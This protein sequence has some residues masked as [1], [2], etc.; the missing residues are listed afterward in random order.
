MRLGCDRSPAG[1]VKQRV[2]GAEAEK[3][4]FARP[5][6]DAVVVGDDV[7]VA[8]CG[9]GEPFGLVRD[10]AVS[11]T[12]R[13]DEVDALLLVA[14]HAVVVEDIV[15]GDSDEVLGLGERSGAVVA[16]D[17]DE[18]VAD[19]CHLGEPD[20]GGIGRL[21]VELVRDRAPLPGGRVVDP[22]AGP[23]GF[24]GVRTGRVVIEVFTLGGRVVPTA[25]LGDDQHLASVALHR[26]H[27]FEPG[28][29]GAAL[30]GRGTAGENLVEEADAVDH[31][32][33]CVELHQLV[34]SG[35][36]RSAFARDP[37][38][39]V[40]R[41]GD[42]LGVQVLGG[43]G[44][45]IGDH[46]GCG[47]D[48]DRE[49]DALGVVGVPHR[50]QDVGVVGVVGQAG[51]GAP[52]DRRPGRVVAGHDVGIRSRA[53]AE[54]VDADRG[55]HP[56]ARVV[57]FGRCDEQVAFGDREQTFGLKAG[58]QDLQE[59]GG[60]RSDDPVDRDEAAALG[61]DEQQLLGSVPGIL[62]RFGLGALVLG[63][64]LGVVAM[65]YSEL[66]ERRAGVVPDTPV[67]V[68]HREPAAAA[69]Q[70]A[71]VRGC[72]PIAADPRHRVGFAGNVEDRVGQRD[73]AIFGVVDADQVD[74]TGGEVTLDRPARQVDHD[75]VVV[76]LERDDS[77]VG[78]VDVDEL[79]FGVLGEHIGDIG[80]IDH[81]GGPAARVADEVHDRQEP[82]RRLRR[83]TVG[84]REVLIALVLDHDRGIPAIG[85]DLDRIG[86]AT[87][88]DGFDHDRCG[89]IGDVDHEQ[90]AGR[91]V[92]A[93]AGV[94]SDEGVC[95]GD[96][97][98]RRLTTDGE[99]PDRHGGGRDRDVGE[100]D[101][102]AGAVGRHQ[103]HPVGGDIDDLGDGLLRDRATGCDHVLVGSKCRNALEAAVERVLLAR[104]FTC[105]GCDQN[106][107]DQR[108]DGGTYC[109]AMNMLG[110]VHGL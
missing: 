13:S 45:C 110:G 100:S 32:E 20:P 8:G 7:C 9:D 92:E 101:P 29:E 18:V 71:L 88:V 69:V 36:G 37:R 57:L 38:R 105:D 83:R 81:P 17:D 84:R 85:A 16:F 6:L 109:F 1:S 2:H 26:S 70:V 93:R 68:E 74:A 42:A 24:A 97:H 106:S 66:L 95:T 12:E 22:Q 64:V 48:V 104:R 34:R 58:G 47:T 3:L 87:H 40:R 94:H 79:G 54:F 30:G 25:L 89:G 80:E 98:R 41:D 4:G 65:A 23:A 27:T 43:V 44:G 90:H 19:E 28:A 107:G 52:R 102:L 21:R 91:G 33:V 78:V 82:T 62:E 63:P 53:G 14:G 56:E 46:R 73:H 5:I 99:H 108:S 77:E 76:L 15:E 59:L 10:P 61:P 60:G 31:F 67:G 49:P 50:I 75:E 96:R 11:G 103:G 72:E 35:V 51:Q 86:L 55:A 39:A